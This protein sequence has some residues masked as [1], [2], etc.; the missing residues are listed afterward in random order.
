[1][2][3]TIEQ[4]KQDITKLHKALEEA[5]AENNT[6]RN[7]GFEIKENNN[8]FKKSV[9]NIAK[10]KEKNQTESELENK[11]TKYQKELA[12][13]EQKY[14]SIQVKLDKH[15]ETQ[16]DMLKVP[17]FSHSQSENNKKFQNVST[18]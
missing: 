9:S 6:L 7:K 14:K 2:K 1:M 12:L 17:P 10:N 15:M 11:Y 16:I 8:M 5:K 4:L 13:A 3:N 18:F